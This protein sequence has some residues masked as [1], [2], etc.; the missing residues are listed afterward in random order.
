MPLVDKQVRHDR[1]RMLSLGLNVDER[2]VGDPHQIQWNCHLENLS[3]MG[4][5]LRQTPTPRTTPTD[6]RTRDEPAP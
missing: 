1:I 3:R 6:L 5:R 4:L 2:P